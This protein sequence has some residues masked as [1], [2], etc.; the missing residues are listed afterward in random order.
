MSLSSVSIRRPVFTTVLALLIVIFGIVG[1]T[2]LGVREYPLAERP[3]ITVSTNYTGAS[4][5]V[6]ENQITEPLETELNVVAGIKTL[7]STSREGRSTIRAEFELG[8]DLDRAANDIRDR[9]AAAA[10]NLP[11]DADPSRVT[12]ADA[13]GDPIVFLNIQ[14]NERDL[15][16]LTDLAENLFK[17]RVENI[18]GVAR[19]DIW[20]SKTYSMRLWIDSSRMAAHGLGPVDIRDA[21]NRANLE[22]PSGYI[23]GAST[24]ITIRTLSRLEDNPEAFERVVLKRDGDRVVRFADIGYAEIAPRNERT[25][26]RRD[27]I[28]MVGLVI[29]PQTGANEIAI[30]DEF[31]RRL[32]ILQPELPDDILLDIGFDTSDYIRASVAEV[33]RTIFIALALVCLTIF[34]F[35]REIRPGIIPLITIPVAITGTFFIL[36]LSGFTINVLTL[37]GL[38]LAVGLVVDDA[39]VVVENI[40]RKIEEGKDS[41]EAGIEGVREIFLAVIAT[42]L[43]LIAVF[44]PI[45][46]LG[47]LTGLLFREFGMT[48]A[49]AV[50]ISSFVALTLGAMLS[51]RILRKRESHPALYRWSEPFFEWLNR[52]YRSMLA[53]MLRHRWVALPILLA[54]ASVMTWLFQTLQQDLIPTEDRSLLVISVSGPQGVNFE[55][56]DQVMTRVDEVVDREVPE[57]TAQISVTSPGFGAGTTINSGFARLVLEDRGKRERGQNEIQR[58]LSQAFAERIPEALVNIFPRAPIRALGRGQPVQF[59]IQHPDFDTLSQIL[60]D[61]RAAAAQ[62]PEFGFVREDLELN[63]PEL[64]IRIDR[65]RADHLGVSARDIAETIQAS[66]SGQR[67]GFFLRDGRQYD[68][69]GQLKRSDRSAPPDLSSL[70][71]RSAHGYPVT[72][73]NLVEISETATAPVRYRYN[74]FPSATFQASLNEDFTIPDGVAAMREIASSLLDDSFTTEL[75]GQS[76]EFEETGRSLVFVFIFALLL[77]YLVLSAQFESFRDPL[78]IM[79]TVPLALM[80]GLLALLAFGETLNLFSQIGLVML[81]GLVTKNGILVVEFA[82]QRQR[83]GLSVME[84]VTEAAAIRF[85]PILMTTTSTILGALP[86][87]LATGEGAETRFP[88]GL[89]VIGGLMIGS[90]LTLF[91]IPAAYT[92]LSSVKA[93]DQE[94]PTATGS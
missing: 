90:F 34:A 47:G 1:F 41:R 36:Y 27:G 42:T 13:D 53:A 56:M 25:L 86:I 73:D 94:L 68:I 83:A 21:F 57:R 45:L 75:A 9:V 28:P 44:L 6:I 22:L 88:L 23:E 72:L 80:G 50:A 20:G 71:V 63:Q 38:V 65:D 3:I 87:V 74:R 66:L 16:S 2:N 70:V 58:H 69:V 49:G 59:V 19:V 82:N 40:Y 37:L 46:F 79:L 84:A 18:A 7:T 60:E 93:P 54:C 48:L 92:F 26:L 5:E 85:R 55:Y 4:A 64:E 33:Q 67:Y 14:S 81:I 91:V 29:R 52:T 30:V 51:S 78:I 77:V 8:E 10:R 31:Y 12:K 76:R 11:P 61:F 89:A 62:R 32:A 43:A 39:I 24:E 35:L 17:P 15:L